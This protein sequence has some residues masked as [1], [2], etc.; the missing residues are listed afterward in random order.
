MNYREIKIPENYPLKS[1]LISVYEIKTMASEVRYFAIPNGYVGIMLGITGTTKLVKCDITVPK[2]SVSGMIVTPL[3]V[4]HGT[5]SWEISLVFN[6]VYLQIILN[7]KMQTL[8]QNNAIDLETVLSKNE[9]SIL[10]EKI[11]DCKNDL[12]LVKVL[13]DFLTPFFNRNSVNKKALCLYNLI[14]NQEIYSTNELSKLLDVSPTTIRNWS[15]DFFGISPKELIQ[16][17]RF[18]KV[19][20]QDDIKKVSDL[21]YDLDYFDQ[22]HFSHSFK[23]MTGLTPNRY[24]KNKKLTFDFYNYKRWLVHNFET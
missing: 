4:L 2:A 22:A 6:P 10:K 16:I 20:N 15:N 17:K 9:I 18:Q 19:L 3:E 8:I 23:Q 12:A 21:A 11:V 14:E 13:Q 1:W 5:H 24:F 7:D